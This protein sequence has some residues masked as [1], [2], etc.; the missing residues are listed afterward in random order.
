MNRSIM[1]AIAVGT[2]VFVSATGC[3]APE[4][5]YVAVAKPDN[6]EASGAP[7]VLLN[8]ELKQKLAVDRPPI[9]VRNPNGHMTIQ[10]GLRNRTDKE[11][12]R[13]QA[14]T[15]FMDETGRVLYSQVGS[16]TAWQTIVL[17]PN[18]TTHYSAAALSTEASRFTVRVRLAK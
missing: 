13:V 10:V 9:V 16:E 15:I 4:G 6:P 5:P 3:K 2:C 14:Q 1:T 17:A 8:Y 7:V 11:I 18:Q 12:L